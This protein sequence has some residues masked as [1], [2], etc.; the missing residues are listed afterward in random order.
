[1][2]CLNSVVHIEQGEKLALRGPNLLTCKVRLNIIFQIEYAR[3]AKE[4]NLP[5]IVGGVHISAMPF[6]LTSD[7]DLGVIG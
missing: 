2:S 7:M 5:V 3:I 1:M 4:Y 6:T